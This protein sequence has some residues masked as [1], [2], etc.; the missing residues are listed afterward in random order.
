MCV[1]RLLSTVVNLHVMRTFDILLSD[2]KKCVSI[3]MIHPPRE[4]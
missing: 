1:G 4:S 3:Q 2:H